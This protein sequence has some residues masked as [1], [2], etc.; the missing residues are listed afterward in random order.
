MVVSWRG[1]NH[2]LYL[3]GLHLIVENDGASGLS[4]V[5]TRLSIGV[6]LK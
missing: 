2:T 6:D 3:L 1:R 5:K 4:I